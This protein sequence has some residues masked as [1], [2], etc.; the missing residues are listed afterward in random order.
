MSRI[1]VSK[2]GAEIETAA[3]ACPVQCFHKCSDGVMVIDA[4]ECIDCGVCQ[5]QAPEG[6]IVTDDEASEAD[7]KFNA[8]KSKECPTA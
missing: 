3:Q 4:D 2:N 6:T 7:I 8:E 5:M 1:V